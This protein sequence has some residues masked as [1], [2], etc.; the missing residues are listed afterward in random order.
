MSTVLNQGVSD[1]E[2]RL[3]DSPGTESP[4]LHSADPESARLSDEE[5]ACDDG[6]R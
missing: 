5:G 3:R 6:I 2:V 4:C 1:I